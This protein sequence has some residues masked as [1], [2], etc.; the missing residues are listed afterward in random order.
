MRFINF[1]SNPNGI[2]NREKGTTFIHI[3]PSNKFIQIRKNE[4]FQINYKYQNKSIEV[5]TAKVE[6][7]HIYEP[8]QL[9]EMLALIAWGYTAQSVVTAF[10]R[11]YKDFDFYKNNLIA[12]ILR[13]NE[14]NISGVPKIHVKKV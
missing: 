7:F 9:S 5:G 10:S 8:A 2:L 14:K 12:I 6:Y 4:D 3:A 1:N 13:W 11:M